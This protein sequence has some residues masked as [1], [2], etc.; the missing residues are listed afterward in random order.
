MTW[1][2]PPAR[3]LLLPRGF[4]FAGLAAG[5]KKSGKLDLGLVDI[6][7]G[8]AAAAV[9]TSNR[10]VAAH[11]EVARDS[12]RAT[13]GRVRAL[14][15]NSGNANCA[16]GRAG[17]R[18]CEA[19]C[20]ALA[21]LLKASAREVFPSSTGVIGIRLP[22]QKILRALPA[23]VAAR[24]DSA[25]AARRFARAIMTTDTR[26]KFAAA[27]FRCRGGPATLLGIAKGAGMIH[28]RLAPP[29]HATMLVY[30]F[31]DAAARAQQLQPLL[32]EAVSRTFNRISVDG[33]TST[34]DTVLLLASGAAGTRLA[35][36]ADR[37]RIAQALESICASL[38][39]QIV[40]DGEGAGHFVDLEVEG[41]RTEAEAERVARAIANSP[42]VKTAWAGA[43][44]NWGR[45]LSAA[46]NSGVAL[47]PRR[48]DIFLGGQQVCRRGAACPFDAR[49]A[50]RELGQ[51]EVSV[52][53][54]LGRGRARVRFW[55]CDLTAE[56]VRENSDYT[57]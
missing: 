18:D 10:V 14:V 37:R 7:R 9:F 46:G 4:R 5:I 17:R 41:A 26:P 47:D 31:T 15:V 39:R 29:A 6:P 30:L 16:N 22:R 34:N 8:A 32:W 35:S 36:Q 38:A 56:Y 11:V 54:R 52:R 33:D 53:V 48:V 42:L 25:A 43:D 1:N 12:L 55:T 51:R 44:P 19:V 40:A 13:R 3:R 20:R 21:R 28:P 50:H 27:P 2:H 49:R 57:T 24:R 23:L 45:I